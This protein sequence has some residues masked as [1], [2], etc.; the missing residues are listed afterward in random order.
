MNTELSEVEQLFRRRLADNR[1]WSKVD[2]MFRRRLAGVQRIIWSRL[3]GK[4]EVG[5]CTE[6]DMLLSRCLEKGWQM[7]KEWSEVNRV[8][9]RRLAD[10][11]RI[12]RSWPEMLI[13][14]WQKYRAWSEVDQMFRRRLA[15]VQR[16]SWSR[17]GVKPE[18][19]RCTEIDMLLSRCLEKGWQIYKEWSEVD[20][21]LTR[22]L[23]DVQR[24]IRSWPEMLIR[25]WQMYTEWYKVDQKCLKD[26]RCIENDLM[27][28]RCLEWRLQRMVSRWADVEKQAGRFTENVWK[29]TSAEKRGAIQYIERMIGS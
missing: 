12:I 27:F 9:T 25:S 6:N 1:E 24:I 11:Q 22:R 4:P 2:Q 17:L 3:G 14:G 23:A 18:V 19:G 7:Y 8:L 10:V 26:G 5:R 16:M 15:D 29:E 13:R 21:V 20:R 28:T